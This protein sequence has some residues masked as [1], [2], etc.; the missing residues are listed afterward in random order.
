MRLATCTL[1]IPAFLLSTSSAIAQGTLT[2]GTQAAADANPQK[3]DQSSHLQT[4]EEALEQDAQGYAHTVGVSIDEARRRVRAMQ[5][6]RSVKSRIQQT[7]ANRLAGISTQ[8]SPQLQVS[9]LLTG[10]V[11]VPAE[12]ISAGGLTVPIV[13]RTGA[14]S[15]L[16]EL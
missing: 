16:Q 6:L 7:Y 5:E 13:Y 14:R 12:S 10:D 8:H 9:V 2:G 4:A 1:L 11:A 15:T 3:E